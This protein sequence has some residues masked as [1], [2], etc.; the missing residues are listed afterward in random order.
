MP[1]L[2]I[3]TARLA[4]GDVQEIAASADWDAAYWLNQLGP[5]RAG[6]LLTWARVF[7]QSISDRIRERIAAIERSERAD[8][9]AKWEAS[10]LTRALRPASAPHRAPR[11]RPETALPLSNEDLL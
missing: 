9:I 6:A 10:A 5:E 4:S 11:P 8:Q 3:N 7:E 2:P 1:A